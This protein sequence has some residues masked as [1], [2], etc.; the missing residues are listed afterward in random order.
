MKVRDYI[1]KTLKKHK[2]HMTLIDPAKQPPSKS[3]EIAAKA[4]RAG[5]DAIMVGGS[6]GVTQENLDMTVDEIKRNCK[7]PVIYFP[8]D[9]H[10]IARRCD[11]IYFMSM[12]NSKNVR[13]ITREHVKGAPIIKK[14]GIEPISMGYVIVEPGMKV[15]EIGEAELVRRDDIGSIVGYAITTEFFGMDLLYL[16]AG[17]GAPEPVPLAMVRAARESVDLPIVLGGGIVTPEQAEKLAAAGADIIVTGTLVENGD[18]EGRLKKIVD[19]V[20]RA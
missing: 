3:G 14:L 1:D 4:C 5:T 11:A 19:M 10:A 13:N 7:L 8:S 17:S 16:E 9:A 2:M 6:T 15:G 18:F 20:H 12:L